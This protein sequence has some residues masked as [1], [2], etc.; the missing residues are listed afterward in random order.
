MKTN[1]IY[2]KNGLKDGIPIF[3]GYFAVSFTFGIAAKNVGM[4]SVQSAV[5]SA[6]NL[7]SAGQFAALGI[8][9][10]GASYMEMAVTQLIINMRYFL[11][12]CSLS[13]KIEKNM[14]FY[15]RFFIAFGITDEIFGVSVCREGKLKPF[16]NYGLIS[17]GAPGW[18]L[19]TVLGVISGNM[20]PQR[21]VSALSIA[22]FA[23]FIAI[24]VPPARKSKVLTGVIFSSMAMSFI[25]TILPFLSQISPGMKIIILTVLIAGVTAYF[26]PIKEEENE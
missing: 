2:W 4:T 6:S 16:Y 19:G 18:V 17:M 11:M 20:L 10:A 13:Q 9:G 25:F 23:M 1:F 24:I 8:I 7:T 15:H 14:P 26:F 5:M 22:I 12:S 21:V 3:L